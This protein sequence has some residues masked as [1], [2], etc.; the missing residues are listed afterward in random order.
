MSRAPS[1]VRIVIADDHPIFRDALRLVLTAEGGFTVVGEACDGDEA[2][3]AVLT[4]RPDLLLLDLSMPRAGGLDALRQL[5]VAGTE[6]R[7]VLLTAAITG[8]ELTTALSLGACGILLKDAS[9]SVLCDCVRAVARGHYWIGRGQV[10]GLLDAV[11][12]IG[13]PSARSASP[14][15]T[16]TPRELQ[17]IGVVLE[18]ASNRDIALRFRL[19]EQT[20]K[21]HL[22][23]VFDKVGVSSRL[24]LALYA[25]HH[26][27]LGRR[28]APPGVA[29]SVVGS[30]RSQVDTDLSGASNHDASAPSSSPLPIPVLRTAQL[31]ADPS[32]RR[33]DGTGE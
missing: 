21:N 14:A 1:A 20:V 33:R 6:V 11:Q 17:I 16:L 9:P 10:Q 18:G 25:R 3:R 5:A 8:T 2:V 26:E 23:R 19:S 27:I 31:R 12:C 13:A 7:T 4:H 32:G 29:P 30:A 24:E 15:G 22:A 28:A